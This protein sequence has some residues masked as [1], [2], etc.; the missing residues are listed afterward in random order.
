VIKQEDS[1]SLYDFV[2]QDHTA[3]TTPPKKKLVRE[4]NWQSAEK[5]NER[6]LDSQPEHVKN[7][8]TVTQ[9]DHGYYG[10]TRFVFGHPPR[11]N[12]ESQVNKAHVEK[13]GKLLPGFNFIPEREKY[14]K[15][16]RELMG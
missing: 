10:F 11:D 13:F 2:G 9:D 15:F 6:Y 4:Q 16:Y 7:A 12:F 8:M 14:I 3:P 1:S 5:V